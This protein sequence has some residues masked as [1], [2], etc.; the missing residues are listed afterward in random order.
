VGKYEIAASMIPDC[1]MGVTRF[2]TASLGGNTEGAIVP[3]TGR[4][5]SCD[6]YFESS[7]TNS[8]VTCTAC[9]GPTG[10]PGGYCGPNGVCEAF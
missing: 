5:H 7:V 8:T 2:D 3:N 10:C 1:A 4:T 9:S 6:C